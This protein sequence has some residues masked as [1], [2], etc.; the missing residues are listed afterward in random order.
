MALLRALGVIAVLAL[1]GAA[2]MDARASIGGGDARTKMTMIVGAAPGGGFDLVARES[3]QALRT[4]SIVNNT[5][6][7]NIPGAAG[8]ISLGQL[9]RMEGDGGTLMVTG[10]VMLGGIALNPHGPTMADTTPIAKLAE[11]FGVIAVPEHSQ[12]RTLNDLIERWKS[13]PA[14]LPIGG[15]SA[16]GIDHMLAAVLAREAGI[17][18]EELKYSAYAGG[19]ELTVSLL[20]TAPGTPEIGI[21]SYNEFR[22]LL[23]DG[24]LRALAVVAPE[25]IDGVDAP[26]MIE[27]GFPHVNLVNWRGLVA[28]SDISPDQR[29]ELIDVVSEMHATTEWQDTMKRNQWK[30]SFLTGDEFGSFLQQEQNRVSQILT[31]V[32]LR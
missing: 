11:D 32:G 16:G 31:D 9:T 2:A 10:A 30:D 17:D 15:G 21:S 28:P 6:V 18:P 23:E 25:R 12:F 20:S 27:A 3:Q 8:T 5:Q 14:A 26:T 22:D 29:Q 7:V 1:V 13:N 4:N 24:R 19:G